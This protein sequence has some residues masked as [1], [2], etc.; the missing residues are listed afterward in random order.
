[1]AYKL[2]DT[3]LCRLANA[4]QPIAVAEW[5]DGL[6]CAVYAGGKELPPW[7]SHKIEELLGIHVQHKAVITTR[8]EPQYFI[9]N[10][11][12]N[13]DEFTVLRGPLSADEL[14]GGRRKL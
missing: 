14:M 5:I 4:D 7:A 3:E 9:L 2:A 13:T 12:Y 11:D 8:S 10:L 1:M 6:G